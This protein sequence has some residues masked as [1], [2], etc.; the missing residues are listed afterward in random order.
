MSVRRNVIT[1]EPVLFAPE[2]AARPRAFTGDAPSA[3]RC[4]FCP[5]HEADTP[6]E[7]ARVG[8]EH[9]WIARAFPN[10]YPAAPG[11]EVIVESA[12]HGMRF[13]AVEDAEAVVRL[14]ADR[15]RAHGEAAYTAVFR[16]EGTAAGSSV[17]HAHSQLVPL[18]F[19]PPRIER[20]RAAFAGSCPLCDTLEMHRREGLV[21]RETASFVWL[22]PWGS[23]LP[24]QQW[25]VPVRHVAEMTAF[26]AAELGALLR[27]VARAT[28]AVAAAYNWAFIN[29]PRGNGH[30]YVDVLPRMTGI[31][32]FELGTGTFVEIVE[33][34]AAAERLRR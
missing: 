9:A 20:E 5:G 33:P 24:Y 23:T 25:I 27:E 21:I 4:P 16:N 12:R 6:P 28:G 17:D 11:A 15:Y 18:P 26:D 30:A 29:F 19:V 7:L 8:D 2:R 3:E 31:A 13:E 32:G 1:G 14:Y 22:A 10:K 34:A